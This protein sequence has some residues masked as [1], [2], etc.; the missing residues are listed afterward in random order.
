M[1]KFMTTKLF[2]LLRNWGE[3]MKLSY[4]N[5]NIILVGIAL[6]FIVSGII[7]LMFKINV[8]LKISSYIQDGLLVLACVIFFVGRKKEVEEVKDDEGVKEDKEK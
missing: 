3:Q 8:D 4:R 2:R 6:L 1:G 7:Q 5:R